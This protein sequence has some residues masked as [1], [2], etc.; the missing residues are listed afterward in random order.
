MSRIDEPIEDGQLVAY[1]DGE[2]D[3][4]DARKVEA[5]IARDP[6]LRRKVELFRLT[7]SI[8]REAFL[9]SRHGIVS[10]HL[11]EKRLGIASSQTK[12]R[13]ALLRIALAVA[14]SILL[15]VVGFVVGVWHG[16]HF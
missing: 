16:R 15:V 10:P 3:G 14:A 9:G 12:R 11:A 2:L 8:T 7:G 1:V 4:A 5:A 6:E 13:H